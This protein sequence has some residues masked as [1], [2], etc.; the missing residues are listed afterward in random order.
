[1]TRQQYTLVAE[2]IAAL[3]DRHVRV[4]TAAAHAGIYEKVFSGFNK[5][6]FLKA[7]NV[8]VAE[9]QTLTTELR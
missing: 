9:T 2:A 3:S 5:E 6:K 7:C 1:M 8:R 4:A